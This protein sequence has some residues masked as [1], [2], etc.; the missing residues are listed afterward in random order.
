[1]KLMIASD[2]HGSA[3]YAG[4]LMDAFGREQPDKLLLLGDFLYHGPRNELPDGYDPKR[5]FAM[6]NKIK[7]SILAVR[8]NCDSEVD[9]MVLEF[10]IM[11]DCCTLF[12]DGRAIFATHG[13]I[14]G[15]DAPPKLSAGD[16]LLCGHTHLPAFDLMEGGFTYVNP[17]SVSLPKEGTARGY[18]LIEGGWLAHREL[19]GRELARHAL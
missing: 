15:P 3:L 14:Y 6:L 7:A 19:G 4:Q 8:G 9:Q 17:G 2:I 5:V 12:L 1:M 10:P 18:M 11:A 16:L 13:H